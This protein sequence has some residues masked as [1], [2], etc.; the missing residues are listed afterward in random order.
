MNFYPKEQI[1]RRLISNVE[2][3]LLILRGILFSSLC[4][5]SVYHHWPLFYLNIRI[6]S[7]IFQ[8]VYAYSDSLISPSL[9][10]TTIMKTLPVT[11]SV[12]TFHY[13]SC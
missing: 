4:S 6:I 12:T 9:K 8:N 3:I 11:L 13:K 5:N 10:Q 1:D 7:L 2:T